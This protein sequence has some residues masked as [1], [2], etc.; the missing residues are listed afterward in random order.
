MK[1][2]INFNCNY[3]KYK[4]TFYDNSYR[5]FEYMKDVV[6]VKKRCR[7]AIKNN[8]KDII[9]H[10]GFVASAIN[11]PTYTLIRVNEKEFEIVNG[12]VFV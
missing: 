6:D 1:K 9:S 7:F 8:E 5:D 11:S 12:F 3:E 2:E 10:Y 4:I